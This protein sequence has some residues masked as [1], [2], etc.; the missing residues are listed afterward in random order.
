[1]LEPTQKALPSEAVI[2]PTPRSR[3][4]TSTKRVKT[5]RRKTGKEQIRAQRELASV[6]STVRGLQAIFWIAALGLG[7]SAGSILYLSGSKVSNPDLRNGIFIAAFFLLT[8]TLLYILGALNLKRNPF[9]WSLAL[10]IPVTLLILISVAL[11]RGLPTIPTT[12]MLL[13]WMG[14]FLGT[15]VR[16]LIRLY[17]DLSLAKDLKYEASTSFPKMIGITAAALILFP[18]LGAGFQSMGQ[19]S[20]H[21]IQAN[22]RTLQAPKVPLRPSLKQFEKAWK[23]QDVE[24]LGAL[25]PERLARRG[26]R[27]GARLRKH[28]FEDFPTLTSGPEVENRGAYE[29]RVVYETDAGRI[30]L[31]YKFF[32]DH[33]EMVALKM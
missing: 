26:R 3:K 22:E 12:I 24:A 10:A 7:F 11:R 33:W 28:G 4:R 16:K 23:A 17:P 19:G 30:Q 29:K 15:K 20:S 31:V 9:S 14:V 2:S 6:L 21:P 18:L 25:Y 5:P 1:M 27:L 13:S 8:L 32:E